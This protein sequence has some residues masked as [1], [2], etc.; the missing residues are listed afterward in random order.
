[1]FKLVISTILFI[2]VGLI[3]DTIVTTYTDVV[4]LTDLASLL[5]VY[6]SLVVAL[7]LLGF[8]LDEVLLRIQHTDE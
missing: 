4:T 3:P 7:V 6:L 2:G 1:M 8:G 5:N